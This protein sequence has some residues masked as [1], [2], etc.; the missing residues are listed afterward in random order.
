[1]KKKEPSELKN[2][3]HCKLGAHFFAVPSQVKWALV[4]LLSSFHKIRCSF[5]ENYLEWTICGWKVILHT[6]TWMFFTVINLTVHFSRKFGYYYKFSS[7]LQ[8]Q[9]VLTDFFLRMHEGSRVRPK[10]SETMITSGLGTMS[11]KMFL[12]C[13]LI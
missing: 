5:L 3:Q 8:P 11:L 6:K 13:N 2:G 12:V 7:K 9:D 10:G 4:V 1:M